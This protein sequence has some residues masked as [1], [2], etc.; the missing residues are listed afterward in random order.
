MAIKLFIPITVEIEDKLF[1]IKVKDATP[2]DME[3]I[4]KVSQ[5]AESNRKALTKIFGELSEVEEAMKINDGLL[6][7]QDG[8][9]NKAKLWLEQ[10]ELSKE[11]KRLKALLKELPEEIDYSESFKKR[12]E[13]LVDG[14]EKEALVE[15]IKKRGIS[16]EIVVNEINDLLNKEKKKK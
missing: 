8:V 7:T 4:Q 3:E 2:S 11:K 9:I 13:L 5:E 14:E 12:F 6:E 15:E 1:K 10:K 16:Y